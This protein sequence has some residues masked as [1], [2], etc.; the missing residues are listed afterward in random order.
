V[1]NVSQKLADDEDCPAVRKDF[2]CPSVT[3]INHDTLAL[4]STGGIAT[5]SLVDL[6]N[7]ASTFDISQ[8]LRARSTTLNGVAGKSG[9]LTGAGVIISKFAP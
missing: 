9:V 5:S 6:T 8:A 7:A 1:S 3:S 4:A 2:R